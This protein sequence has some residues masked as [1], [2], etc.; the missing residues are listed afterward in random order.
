[1]E[2]AKIEKRVGVQASSERLW[3]LLADLS[4]WDRWNP[5]ETG[6]QGAIAFGGQISLTESIPGLPDRPTTVR[7][8]DWQPYAQ[9][10]WAEKR[11]WAFNV[12]RYFE[13]EELAPGNCIVSNG[14]IFSG[15]RG[16][17]FHDKHRKTLRA[18]CEAVAE[19][20]RTAALA[21]D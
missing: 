17:L 7:I 2:T 8:G 5:V 1:M 3:D 16:E 12:I 4:G 13:I 14:F 18:A 19:G 6:L 9:L 10:I 11:G 21:D 20:L 15:L